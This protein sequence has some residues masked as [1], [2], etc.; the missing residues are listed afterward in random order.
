MSLQFSFCPCR[1]TLIGEFKLMIFSITWTFKHNFGWARV[2]LNK[3]STVINFLRHYYP[4][5]IHFIM[6]FNFFF[7]KFLYLR[8]ILCSFC[9]FLF[10]YF[11]LSIPFSC[12][13]SCCLGHKVILVNLWFLFLFLRR[14][15]NRC[16]LSCWA[17]WYRLCF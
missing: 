8:L 4:T 11:L 3:W 10:S 14:S 12:H 7:R 2:S 6:F 9:L 15:L 17:C 1:V 5:V 13:P 16:G